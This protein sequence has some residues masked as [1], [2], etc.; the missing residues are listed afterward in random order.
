MAPRTGM[1]M[2]MFGSMTFSQDE[3]EDVQSQQIFYGVTSNPANALHYGA[4][5]GTELWYGTE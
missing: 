2:P 1:V 5:G 3:E 4:G